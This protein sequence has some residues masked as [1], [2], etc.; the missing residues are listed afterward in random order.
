MSLG[1]G[2]KVVLNGLVFMLDPHNPKSF[3]PIGTA[4]ENLDYTCVDVVGGRTGSIDFGMY[5]AEKDFFTCYGLTYPEPSQTPASRQG[6]TPGRHV[7]SGT[8]TY[9]MSRDVGMFVFD[10]DSN[11]WVPDSY[12]NGERIGGHCY[13][14]YDGAPAQHD[15]FQE[16]FNIINSTFPN[17][18]FILIGSHAAENLDANYMTF[19]IA[20]K[21][22]VPASHNGVG[23][24]EFVSVGK[25]NKPSTWR[26]VRENISSAVGK[27]VIGLPFNS[28]PKQGIRFYSNA[29]D[30]A[31]S[32]ALNIPREKTLSIW[33]R[34]DRPLSTADNWE[35]GFVNSGSTQ[36]AMFGFMYGVGNCQDL[37]Y[38]GYG[39]AYDMSVEAVNNKWSSDGNWHNAVITM[40]SS[41][42]VR[43]WVDGEQKQWLK[44]TDYSTKADYVT[45]PIDTTN[46]FVIN[47]RAPWN[48]GMTY[49]DLG[50]VMVYDRALSD[51]EIKKNYEAL[52]GRYI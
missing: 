43:V 40:D 31:I 25:Y 9:D 14:F 51:A 17:A 23:R 36:G 32:P 28:V 4:S 33:I 30:I 27:M 52:K 50:N 3:H 49:V 18:T 22:G 10:D 5:L 47:S 39:S 7:T 13:D 21:L 46:N 20:K 29:H 44:H 48:S 15:R 42:N 34:S 2:S 35:I 45:M 26:Y 6:I 24:P 19:E 37:G 16:D 12:F 38:W 11:S 1:H 41:R 8:K